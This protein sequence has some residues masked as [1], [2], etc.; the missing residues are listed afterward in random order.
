MFRVA[1]DTLKLVK[2]APIKLNLTNTGQ[3]RNLNCIDL[4]KV[5]VEYSNYELR[6]IGG[7]RELNR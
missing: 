5:R 4:S 1:I 3:S 7:L 6:K 2:A